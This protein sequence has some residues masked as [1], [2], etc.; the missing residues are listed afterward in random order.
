VIK[1]GI[2]MGYF[3]CLDSREDEEIHDHDF[4]PTDP[5]NISRLP[6]TSGS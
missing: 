4:N 5:F 2:G 6:S 3:S 1:E